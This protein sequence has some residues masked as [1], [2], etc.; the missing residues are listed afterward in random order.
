MN[1]EEEEIEE[2]GDEGMLQ[3]EDEEMEFLDEQNESQ[4]EIRNAPLLLNL[5]KK[6][7]SFKDNPLYN[8]IRSIDFQ[9]IY[10]GYIHNYI[11][12]LQE[13]FLSLCNYIHYQYLMLS[14]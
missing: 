11:E 10:F 13:I 12:G 4:E 8:Q 7:L 14:L 1:E 6:E 5:E 2:V 3:E 9:L